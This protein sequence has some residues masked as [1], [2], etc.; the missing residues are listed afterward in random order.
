MV[1]LLFLIFVFWLPFVESSKTRGAFLFTPTT[2]LCLL[3][4]VEFRVLLKKKRWL[5]LKICKINV[6]KLNPISMWKIVREVQEVGIVVDYNTSN[7]CTDGLRTLLW[8]RGRGS[9]FEVPR[10]YRKSEDTGVHGWCLNSWVVDNRLNC[11]TSFITLYQRF[12]T[13]PSYYGNK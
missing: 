13:L 10:T 3:L 11:S 8:R 6:T 12:K 7:V 1:L 5:L 2:V 4:G 9:I